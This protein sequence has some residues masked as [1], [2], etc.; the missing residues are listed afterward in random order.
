MQDLVD[1][2]PQDDEHVLVES[3][4]GA[5]RHLL[6]QVVAGALPPERSMNDGRCERSIPFVL[7]PPAA[8]HESRWKVAMIGADR[9]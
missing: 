1:A 3:V 9:S 2:E 7:Q 4:E 6:N 5:S 8:V